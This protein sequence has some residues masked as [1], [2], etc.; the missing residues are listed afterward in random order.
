M[1]QK[2][3]YCISYLAKYC[4]EGTKMGM[5]KLAS[6]TP[7]YECTEYGIRITAAIQNVL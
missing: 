1:S 5:A 6:S 3:I 7:K 2:T 4:A